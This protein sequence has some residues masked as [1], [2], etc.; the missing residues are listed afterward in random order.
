MTY[1]IRDKLKS[2]NG[3]SIPYIC[4]VSEEHRMILLCLHGFAGDKDSSVIAA[5]ME[6]LDE[7]GIG[8]VAFDWPAHGESDA[9]DSALT[10]ENCLDDL[11]TVVGWISQNWDMPV[12]CFATSF[13]GYLATLYRNQNPQVFIDMVLRSPALKM[14][15]IFRGLITDEDFAELMHGKEI[16]QGF[17]R[18]MKIS[19]GFYDSLCRHD[20]YSQAPPHPEKMLII[21]GDADSVVNPDDTREYTMKNGINLALFEG[22][23]HVYKKPGEKERIVT[24]AEKFFLRAEYH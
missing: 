3:W 1:I 21:Q 8:V 4:N 17:D 10:V 24:E 20:A 23:D 6:N 12:S 11:D 16:I 7:K 15:E 14:N 18:K 5:L 19:K 9:P 13:G 22:T 2:A